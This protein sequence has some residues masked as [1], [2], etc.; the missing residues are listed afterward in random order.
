MVT[1]K[2]V[3]LSFFFEYYTVKWLKQQAVMLEGYGN[4]M[5]YYTGNDAVSL[6][7]LWYNGSY[8]LL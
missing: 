3:F 1:H 2:S 4:G 5:Y 7:S 6:H 8:I